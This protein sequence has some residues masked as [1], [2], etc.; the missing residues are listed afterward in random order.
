MKQ[1]FYNKE[2]M[3]NS[4][5]G[6]R[7]NIMRFVNILFFFFFLLQGYQ[8]IAQPVVTV[9]FAN[10][11]FDCATGDYCLDVEFQ[12]DTPG[13]SLFGMNVR[14][15]YDDLVLE[16]SHYA[17]FAEGY[18]A[19]SPDPPTLLTSPTAG[20][21]WFNLANDPA[22]FLNGAIQLVND[23][24]PPIEIST[25]G[26]TKLFAIC[27]DVIDPNPDDNFC[28]SV[29]WDLEADVTAGGFLTGDDGVVMTVVNPDPNL[30]SAPTTEN[31]VQ[32]NWAYSGTGSAPFG[33]PSQDFCI[34]TRCV[35]L[36]LD[37]MVDNAS[38][39]IGDMIT[40][41]IDVVNQGPDDA[42]GVVVTDQL[43][44]GYTYE[45]HSTA[46]GTYDEIT[47]LWDI[48]NLTV[49]STATLTITAT[50]L[51]TGNHI[52]LAEVTSMNG[53]DTDSSVANG[54]DTDGDGLV[55]DDPDDEDDGD[56]VVVSVQGL[57]IELLSFDVEK[58][59]GSQSFLSW[60][61]ASEI[62][63]DYFE[64]QRSDDGLNFRKLGEVK[65]AGTT[66]ETQN[67]TFLD[68]AP[69]KGI[70]Y[71]RLKQF[72]FDG[73]YDFSDIKSVV[74]Q[75][76]LTVDINP[77]PTTGIVRIKKEEEN[78]DRL[79]DYQ[80]DIFDSHGQL[81]KMFDSLENGE[82]D[83]SNLEPGVY[84]IRVHRQGQTIAVKRLVKIN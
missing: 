39:I 32:F 64:V 73:K 23:N 40:F 59:N 81:A 37:K 25:T 66:A 61:T 19:V 31:V 36:A 17:D 62:D 68:P 33:D 46:D 20:T 55:E 44:S 16:Y 51:G 56:G 49:G 15:F 58:V 7:R 9:R 4:F 22:D 2:F 34:S 42:T 52:N 78:I 35:D 54:V 28:P 63:N 69:Y 77:N 6:E 21:A 83:I 30:A 72:D 29:I 3:N 14:L 53:T 80:I 82:I 45:S 38:P 67:Y 10:P 74:F 76:E 41:T 8:I 79:K 27:F 5:K 75:K 50:V 18:G 57:P 60:I 48:G 24:A 84:Q 12:S 47:G 11:S 43:P 70:N 13:E 26:W 71:Y 65:G 1:I